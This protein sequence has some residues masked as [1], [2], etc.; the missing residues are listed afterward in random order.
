MANSAAINR[1]SEMI[2]VVERRPGGS[3]SFGILSGRPNR[4]RTSQALILALLFATGLACS[5]CVGVPAAATVVRGAESGALIPRQQ[6]VRRALRADSTQEYLI[7]VPGKGGDG[8]PL[9]VAAHGISRNAEEHATLFAPFAEKRGVVLVAPYFDP[10][11]HDDY[12]RLGRTG[13]G[14]RA[15]Q[16]LDAILEEVRSLTGAS[17]G[18]VLLFGFS[19]GAQFAHRYTML[20]PD[21]V[22]RAVVAA[23]G[24]YTF[25]DSS[26][27]YPYGIGPT[28]DLEGA[29][30]EP[31]K[32]LRVPIKVLVGEADTGST[33]LR[34]NAAVDRQQGTTRLERARNWAGAMRHAAQE[35][36]QVP[37]VTFEQ[38]PAIKHSFKQF[39][40]EGGLGD[41]VF[42]ALFEPASSLAPR[43]AEPVRAPQ[44]TESR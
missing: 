28:A 22:E 2:R 1:P 26:I 18:K 17:G 32:F 20:H 12:Q 44:G 16:A 42:S 36:G 19:G 43:P 27:T 33:N 10:D 24:W 29:R 40:L 11:E 7:Y 9:F 5:A 21:R 37:L 8:A 4:R 30:F 6:I 39:M 35:R 34:Q 25:P 14:R 15:D 13:R 38:V 41:K 23:A 3:E 31:Q